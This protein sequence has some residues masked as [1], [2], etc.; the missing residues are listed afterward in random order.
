MKS[1]FTVTIHQSQRMLLGMGLFFD[2]LEHILE[3]E[4]KI[5]SE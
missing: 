1:T 5:I 4:V 2:T 3:H